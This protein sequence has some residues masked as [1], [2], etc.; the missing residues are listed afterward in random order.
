ML[1]KMESPTIVDIF[2]TVFHEDGARGKEWRP[3]EST[4]DTNLNDCNEDIG[5]TGH[6]EWKP[7]EAVCDPNLENCNEEL[8]E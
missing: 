2:Y 7:P 4:C 3:P 8:Y 5:R 1:I 6:K